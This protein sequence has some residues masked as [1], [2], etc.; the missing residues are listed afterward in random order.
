MSEVP[1]VFDGEKC[2]MCQ[3]AK[4]IHPAISVCSNCLKM[5]MDSAITRVVSIFGK[6]L[7]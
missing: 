7:A 1:K 5:Q 2:F 3:K 6:R 4:T